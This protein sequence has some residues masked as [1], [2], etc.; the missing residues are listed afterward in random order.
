[1]H[2]EHD[3][4]ERTLR[5]VDLQAMPADRQE[6]ILHAVLHAVPRKRASWWNRPVCF[7]QAAAACLVVWASTTWFMHDGAAV[8]TR[9]QGTRSNPAQLRPVVKHIHVDPALFGIERGPFH[10]IDVRRWR[11]S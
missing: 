9:T 4:F 5:N 11:S 8:G 6:R 2:H 3:A 1:M 10:K 7:W